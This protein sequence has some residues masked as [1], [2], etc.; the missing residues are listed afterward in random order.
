MKLVIDFNKK[1]P[2]LNFENPIEYIILYIWD[3]YISKLWKSFKFLEKSRDFM[4]KSV[5]L[6]NILFSNSFYTRTNSH[7]IFLSFVILKLKR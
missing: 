3:I 2:I 6:E 1:G 4:N 5:I 7:T